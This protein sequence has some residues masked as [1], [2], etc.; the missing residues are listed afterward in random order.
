MDRI[1]RYR[2]FLQVAELGSFIGAANTLGIPRATVSAAVQQLETDLGTR[3]LH[4][5]TRRVQLTHDGTVLREQVRALILQID[6]LEGQFRTRQA[7]IAG[8]VCVDAPTRIARRLIAPH[9]HHLL[10]RHP[11]LEVF[12]GS[13]DRYIDLVKEGIDC[14]IR[15]GE[16]QNSSLVVRTLGHLAFVNCAS[17]HYLGIHGLPKHPDDLAKG[18][19]QVGYSIGAG[20]ASPTW[21]YQSPVGETREIKLPA[22]VTVNNAESYIAC[23]VAGLGLIQVPRFDVQGLL[24]QGRLIEVMPEHRPPATPVSIVYP[25]RRQRAERVVAFAAW[26]AEL[27]QPHLA[28][29]APDSPVRA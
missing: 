4:R 28:D 27:M 29:P 3:L 2:V 5:T 19:R 6:G 7:N 12:L 13:A 11:A 17:P 1:D 24:D 15:V 20:H 26:F 21:E 16:L 22:T 8:R 25:H 9:L 10:S 14:A 23:G 18:H